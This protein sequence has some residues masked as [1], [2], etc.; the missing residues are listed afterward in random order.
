MVSLSLIV[1]E[2]GPTHDA[3]GRHDDDAGHDAWYDGGYGKR[4]GKHGDDEPADGAGL[5]QHDAA[6]AGRAGA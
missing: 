6:A 4:D 2:P 5:L 1:A 3:H